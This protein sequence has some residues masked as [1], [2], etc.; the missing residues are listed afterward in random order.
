[1]NFHAF[2][3]AARVYFADEPADDF[4]ITENSTAPSL[5]PSIRSLNKWGLALLNSLGKPS[6]M[7]GK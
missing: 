1:M 4:E 6:S 5:L 2:R 7:E 3:A